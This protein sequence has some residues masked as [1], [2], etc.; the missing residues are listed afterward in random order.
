MD[1]AADL[2]SVLKGN[3]SA[4]SPSE[5]R[6]AAHLVEHPDIWGFRPTT[7]VAALMGMHRSTIV[8]FAQRLGFTGFPGLQEAVRA[9]YMDSVSAPLDLGDNVLA[10]VHESIIRAI[11]ERELTN[12]RSTYAKLDLRVLED[13]ARRIAEARNVLVFG[14]RF[15]HAIALGVS[16][17][18]RTL[19]G[20]VRI[21]PE[22]GGSSLDSVFDLNLEDAA[23]VVSL[24]RH[25]PSV[26]RM[27]EHLEERQVPT[28]LMTDASP[29]A[30]IP[31]SVQVLHAHIGSTSTLDSF[32]SLVSVGHTLCTLVGRLMPD[33]NARWRAVESA[34]SKLHVD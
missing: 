25:S 6:L 33:A 31:S 23:L 12:L 5:E 18:L 9:L 11:V 19:R 2:F 16:L 29:V 34:R 17:T 15:S 28:T 32:T 24:R 3:A 4:L 7:E 30:R 8:R 27:L 26:Q 21:A 1:T 10:G 20:G 13:T 14:R 22:Q